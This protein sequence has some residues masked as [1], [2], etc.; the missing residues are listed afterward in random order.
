MDNRLL[1]NNLEIIYKRWP[2]LVSQLKSADITGVEFVSDTP[3]FTMLVDGLHIGSC[4]DRVRE[5]AL[6]A[7]CIHQDMREVWV[8]GVGLGDLP[9]F[10]LSYTHLERINVC[11]FSERVLMASLVFFD[12]KDW[13][14]D[15]RVSLRRASN[16]DG[17]RQPFVVSPVCLEFIGDD[18]GRIRDEILL[19][20]E[21]PYL[22]ARYIGNKE[23]QQQLINNDV[24]LK[25]DSKLDV[26]LS[27]I[28]QKVAYV[29]GAGPSLDDSIQELR[30]IDRAQ[31]LII[32]VD[33]ALK[34]LLSQGIVPHVVVTI[35]GNAKLVSKMFDVD[36]ALLKN[37]LLVYFPIVDH[38]V[39]KRWPGERCAVVSHSE[40]FDAVRDKYSL[41]EIFA[42]G[43]VFHP[44]VDL[45]VKVGC[46]KVYFVGADMSYPTGVTHAL[47]VSHREEQAPYTNAFLKSVAGGVVPTIRSF[48]GYVMDLEAYIALHP[49]VRFVNCSRIGAY[50]EG[51]Q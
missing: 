44:A 21:T 45:A 14:S 46:E 11:F 29:V 4:F 2:E 38:D 22:K 48:V 1:E 27:K 5:A 23:F 33:A 28:N 8:Y 42:S 26:V 47:G 30:E 36:L 9:R 39:I 37:S 3:N 49:E 32:A 17:L 18:Q 24:F 25:T 51:A 7:G 34:P 16:S 31:A 35:D 12:H 20:L 6:Q 40:L 50:I 15:P 19:F 10:V 41:R 13:L 43:T